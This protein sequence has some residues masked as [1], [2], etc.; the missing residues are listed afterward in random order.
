MK[1]KKAIFISISIL[2]YFVMLIYI[3]EKEIILN[4]VFEAIIELLT[5]PIIIAT[6]V[7]FAFYLKL[8]KQENWRIKS[9]YLY[10]NLVLISTILLMGFFS[11]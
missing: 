7:L 3:S 11:F 6:L 5:I 9:V 4:N 1:G 8:W 2:L 10:A